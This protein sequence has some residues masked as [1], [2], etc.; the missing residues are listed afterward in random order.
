MA[1]GH[2]SASTR[3]LALGVLCM[4]ARSVRVCALP[5]PLRLCAQGLSSQ[6]TGYNTSSSLYGGDLSAQQSDADL[7]SYWKKGSNKKKK[8][9]QQQNG[10]GA[11][12]QQAQQQAKKKKSHT[13][14]GF[15]NL[16]YGNIDES[17]SLVFS[18]A[19]VQGRC[20]E[21]EKDYLRLTSQA[22]PERV[23]SPDTLAKALTMV[24]RKWIDTQ[25]Y[26]YCCN[27]LKAIRQD[28]TVQ[29][30]KDKVS[31]QARSKRG[32]ARANEAA[33]AA[34]EQSWCTN[35]SAFEP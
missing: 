12:S 11:Q 3:S 18:Q 9:Q 7:E 15:Q 22:D 19:R 17:S 35:A 31:G 25:D 21:L 27:Q 5:L 6:R 14:A 8:K 28:C 23:R 1:D 32:R 33:M 29:H 24:K 30:L 26:E 34:A 10:A 16:G 13:P 2:S 20:L 4:F